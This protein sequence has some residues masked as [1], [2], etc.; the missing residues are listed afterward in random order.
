MSLQNICQVRTHREGILSRR[1][2]LVAGGAAGVGMLGWRQAM[3]DWAPELRRRQKSCILL[4]MRG[5]PSQFESFD[6]KP[7]NTN[8]GPTTAI[9][10]AVSGIKVASQ[11]TNVAREMQNIS[12]IRSMTGREG[13]HQRAVYQMHTGY[14]P[15]GGVRFPSIG[16][17][18]ASEIA[19][20]E[21]DLP[22]FVFVGGRGG[23][24]GSGFLGM[25]VAPF[26]VGDPNQMPANLRPAGGVTNAR[27]GRRLG[28]MDDLEQE[29]A[30]AGAGH[31]VENH[32]NLYQGAANMVRSPRLDAFDLSREP[33]STRQRYGRNAFGQG[34]L[35]ARRLTEAGVT[36]VEVDLGGWDTH[37]NNFETTTR[38]GTQ[39]DAGFGSLVKDLKDRGRLDNTLV[40]WMGEFGRTP[41][42]NANNGR[43]H[44]P[45]AFTVALAG[46]GVKGGRVIGGT[47]AGG[48]DVTSRPVTVADLFCTFCGTLG[49]DSRKE[50][51]APNGRP[52]KIVDGGRAVSE[53]LS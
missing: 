45:R 16:S 40:I 12:L 24:I 22:S 17:I 3:A 50:N 7:G 25:S 26:G 4:F 35:L 11:W 20:K 18:V 5:G 29:F 36:F 34:C 41:R 48:T 52:I 2:F 1:H 14:I 10:T 32:H 19:P 21:F 27:F 39:A 13:E 28:L 30:S 51:H 53:L 31:L 23:S 43:D 9:D 8:G 42:I 47:N 6:P 15:A 44:Y 49:I 33:A 46:G 38:L 37:Q